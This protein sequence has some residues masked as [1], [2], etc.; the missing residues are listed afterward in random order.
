MSTP[1]KKDSKNQ[2]SDEVGKDLNLQ[3]WFFDMI[4]NFLRS[5][6]WKTPVM[7]FLDDNCIIFDTEDENKLEYT[8]VHNVLSSIRY[9][10]L[11]F[12]EISRRSLR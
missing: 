6:R 12:Q 5:P 2:E 7:T 4:I 1:E 8:E 10:L 3:D 9:N 11:E